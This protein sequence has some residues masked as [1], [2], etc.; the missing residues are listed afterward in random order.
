[1]TQVMRLQYTCQSGEADEEQCVMR[2][3]KRNRDF[4][5]LR[6]VLGRVDICVKLFVGVGARF[7]RPLPTWIGSLKLYRLSQL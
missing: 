1:M 6:Q 2:K 7:P 3:Q 5:P 4:R